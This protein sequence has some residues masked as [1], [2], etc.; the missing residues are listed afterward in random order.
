MSTI[1]SQKSLVDVIKSSKEISQE[2]YK[3][4]A[5]KYSRLAYTSPFGQ[6]LF[7]KNIAFSLKLSI[8]GII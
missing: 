6:Q 4:V 3:V 8:V 5:N 2:V 7:C 1:I